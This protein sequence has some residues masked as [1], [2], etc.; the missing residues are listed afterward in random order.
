MR[1][2]SA[3][4][5]KVIAGAAAAVA[6]RDW[7]EAKKDCFAA[8]A[9]AATVPEGENGVRSWRGRVGLDKGRKGRERGRKRGCGQKQRRGR[10]S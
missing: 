5:K 10:G 4:R 9:A 3:G 2:I 6:G 8:A 7:K 1:G